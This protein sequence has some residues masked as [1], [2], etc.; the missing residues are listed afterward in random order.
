MRNRNTISKNDILLKLKVLSKEKEIVQRKLAITAENLALKAQLLS[1]TAK[2]KEIVRRKLITTAENLAHKAKQL[3]ST[4]VEKEIDRKELVVTAENLALIAKELAVTAK[5]K[6]IVK[7]KLALT[8]R[9]LK[10]SYASLEK[11]VLTRTKDLEDSNIATRNLL[12]DLQI[13]KETLAYANAKDEALLAS[14]GDGVIAT[15]KEGKIILMNQAAHNMLGLTQEEIE[16]KTLF[17]VVSM[18]DE[19]G[20]LLVHEK[21]PTYLALSG[22]TTTSLTSDPTYYYVRKDKTTF[23][24]AIKVSPILSNKKIM[25]AIEVFRDITKEREID[26]AK[27]EFVS[28]A[29]HQLRTPLGIMKWYLEALG[30]EDNFKNSSKEIQGYYNEVYKSNER[31]LS[32]VRDLLSVSRIEQGRVKNVPKSV[33]LKQ[34]ITEIV[35]QMQIVAQKKKI[36]MSVSFADNTI[37]SIMIDVLRFHE[38]VENLIGNAIEYTDA[39]GSVS[40]SV[41]KAGESLLIEIKDTGIGISAA[42]QKSLF[43]KFFRSEKAV[44]HNPEGSGLGLYLVKSYVEGWGGKLAVESQEKKGSTF[45]ISLPLKEVR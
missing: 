3:A 17:E 40:V 16:D 13:E 2:G 6:E 28:L 12:E 19:M 14:I 31:V 26:K 5:E 44:I 36:S 37:P 20:N 35:D 33:N 8:A 4:A 41:H 18:V 10:E 32:L 29:S 42:D 21:R 7:H 43:T 27:S 30:N 25:G 22:I 34:I 39:P 15:D 1:E 38:V 9:K 45:T 23:P 24:I 11:K